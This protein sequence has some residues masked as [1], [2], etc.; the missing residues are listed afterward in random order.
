MDAGERSGQSRVMESRRLDMTHLD[1]KALRRNHQK[2][3]V[4]MEIS[5]V[6]V[7]VRVENSSPQ[8]GC[9]PDSRGKL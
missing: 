7:L 8:L 4:G 2:H 3:S 1:T 9:T 5:T 6:Q